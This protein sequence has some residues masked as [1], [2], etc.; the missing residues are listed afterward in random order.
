[1]RCIQFLRVVYFF[2]ARASDRCASVRHWVMPA[3]FIQ[4]YDRRRCACVCAIFYVRVP[5]S[6]ARMY[7]VLGCHGDQPD[8]STLRSSSPGLPVWKRPACVRRYKSGDVSRD[9]QLDITT[10]KQLLRIRRITQ[11]AVA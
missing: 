7:V 10:R 3:E 9:G 11:T 4:Q 5:M 2:C 1:M 8:T 6:Q